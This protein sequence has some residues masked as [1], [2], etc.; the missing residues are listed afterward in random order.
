MQQAS[1][2][3]YGRRQVL[4]MAAA[5]AGGAIAAPFILESPVRGV[6]PSERIAVGFIG[7]GRMGQGHLRAFLEYPEAQVVAVCDVDRWRREHAK[8]SVEKAYSSSAPTGGYKGCPAHEDLRELLARA[9]VDAVVIATGDRWHVPAGVLA[10]KAGKDVYCEKPMSLTIREA[11]AMVEVS[12]RHGQVFQVGLQQRSTP[13]FQRACAM[14]RTGRIGR[15]RSVHVGFPGTAG[16]VNLPAEPVPEGL[17]WERWLGPAPWRPFN[18]RFHQTGEPRD[19]VPWHFCPDFGAGNLTSNT[20]HA[21]D[22]VQWGLGMDGSGPVEIT[23]PETGLVPSLTYRY[24]N[25]VL[26]QVDWKLD[27]KKHRVP[28]G[29]N[30]DEALQP[31]GALFVGDEGWIHVGRQGFLRSHPEEIAARPAG[32]PE[33]ARPVPDHHHDWLTSIRSRGRPACDVMIGGG[34]TIVAHL[35]VIAH[36]TRRSLA[37]DPVREEFIGDDEANRMRSRAMREPWGI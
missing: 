22:V 9:D 35:G 6:A 8:E 23:P 12:R 31:F 16:E 14:V 28:R 19:V 32:E 1:V 10:A 24:A 25:G 34:S 20:V 26:L 2:R 37:W 33:R 5:A 3:R 4:R 18:A 11:R 17:D 36:R 29:W 13:E 27:P 30:P 7:I 21:F 15:V